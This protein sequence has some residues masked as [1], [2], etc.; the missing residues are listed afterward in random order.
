MV[1][2]PS[3]ECPISS[4]VLSVSLLSPRGLPA[5]SETIYTSSHIY[6][7]WH[8]GIEER[9]I[10]INRPMWAQPWALPSQPSACA[11][12]LQDHF[13]RVTFSSR[14]FA[15][16]LHPVTLAQLVL[17]CVAYCRFPVCVVMS[18][19]GA[20]SAPNVRWMETFACGL[21][22]CAYWIMHLLRFTN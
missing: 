20:L 4:N 3:P 17:G 9:S 13:Q 19:E 22:T 8:G 6:A 15:L 16:M 18:C 11:L 5:G 1:I 7:H 2:H 21:L 14:S 10:A 12:H